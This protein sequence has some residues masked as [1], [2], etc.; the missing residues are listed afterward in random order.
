MNIQFESNEKYTWIGIS[1]F[2]A[3]TFKWKI[4]ITRSNSAGRWIYKHKGKRKEYYF[5]RDTKDVL[6]FKGHNLPFTVDSEMDRF[7]GNAQLNFV[8]DDPQQLK[9]HIEQ[10]CINPDP[11]T[12]TFITHIFR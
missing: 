10:Y 6:I 5:P 11:A 4:I 2:L 1:D 8:T 7:F 9:T 3:T 12:L